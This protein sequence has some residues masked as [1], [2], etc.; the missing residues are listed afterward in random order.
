MS[1]KDKMLHQKLYDA[2]YDQELERER[3]RCKILCQQ[4]NSLSKISS[5][6]SSSNQPRKKARSADVKRFLI[7]LACFMAHFPLS[8]VIG[9]L[10]WK[11]YQVFPPAVQLFID[12]IPEIIGWSFFLQVLHYACEDMRF[13]LRSVFLIEMLQNYSTFKT[14]AFF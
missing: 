5:I 10:I 3:I 12:R 1:E 2:N 8:S 9:S 13:C 14:Q 6:H 4:Y 7:R 11:K